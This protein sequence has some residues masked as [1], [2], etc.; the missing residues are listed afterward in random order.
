M[1]SKQHTYHTTCYGHNLMSEYDTFHTILIHIKIHWKCVLHT[2][3]TILFKMVS[4]GQ[5]M[6]Y[7]AIYLYIMLCMYDL[8]V[9]NYY[10]TY[11]W[12]HPCSRQERSN[13]D[14]S[15]HYSVTML[16]KTG[17]CYFLRNFL[18]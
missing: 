18:S 14:I 8:S 6:S 16:L 5:C 1:T 15:R 10:Y 9:W 7:V 17:D 4:F 3:Y 2:F 12:P 11:T 13:E